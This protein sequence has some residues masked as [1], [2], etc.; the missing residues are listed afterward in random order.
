M[1]E[2]GRYGDLALIYKLE[3]TKQ[4]R[5]TGRFQV[6]L[7]FDLFNAN[8]NAVAYGVEFISGWIA[9]HWLDDRTTLVTWR[10][11]DDLMASSK[12]KGLRIIYEGMSE[13][14]EEAMAK[15]ST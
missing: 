4:E 7:S 11:R 9:M 10:R 2:V 15:S 8:G 5:H 3:P 13:T 1:A 14:F 6:I 12:A